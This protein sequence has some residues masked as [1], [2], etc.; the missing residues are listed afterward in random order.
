MKKFNEWCSRIDDKLKNYDFK[1]LLYSMF[2]M[3]FYIKPD[4]GRVW[5]NKGNTN[6]QIYAQTYMSD[7]DM[8]N[9]THIPTATNL[10]LTEIKEKLKREL[11]EQIMN[12]DLIE[13]AYQDTPT[14]TQISA[15]LII[16]KQ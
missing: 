6:I 14:G 4:T 13:W 10:K 7:S 2:P 16:N 3:F 15:R 11:F 8:L 1:N 5:V 12:N 9:G